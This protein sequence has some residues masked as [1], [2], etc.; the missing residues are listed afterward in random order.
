MEIEPDGQQF[1]NAREGGA[2]GAGRGGASDP[3]LPHP[4][5]RAAESR[6]DGRGRRRGRAVVVL[7]GVAFIAL[8]GDD[9]G[10]RELETGGASITVGRSRRRPRRPPSPT[11]PTTTTDH[12]PA[13]HVPTRRPSPTSARRAVSH[14]ATPSNPGGRG[15]AC[16]S[17]GIDT[18]VT[19]TSFSQFGTD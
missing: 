6:D 11:A 17:G 16:P 15:H 3:R 7:G 10:V 14:R 19:A 4:R 9:E 12:H 1:L 13:T 18:Q 5:R 2:A 8:S